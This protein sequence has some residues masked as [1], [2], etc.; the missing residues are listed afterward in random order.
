MLSALSAGKHVSDTKHGKMPSTEKPV[1]VPI[2]E[3]VRS[4][5]VR[6]SSLYLTR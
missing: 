4:G 5:H 2:A 3:T 1:S 6:Y